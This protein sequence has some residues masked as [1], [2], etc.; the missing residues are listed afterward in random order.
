MGPEMNRTWATAI[1]LT[2]L[3]VGA[4][5]LRLPKLDLRPM[6]TDEAVQADKSRILMETGRYAYNPDEFHGPSLH[7][8]ALPSMW[9]SGGKYTDCSETTFRIVPAI[10]GGLLVALLW[11]LRDALGTPGMLCAAVLLALSPS[12]VF[13]SRYYI[14]ETPLIFGN[15]M[16]L[17]CAW[18]YLQ[19]P[20]IRW[21]ALTGL[22]LAIMY[23]TKETWV[24]N[25]AAAGGA[26]F[27]L[28]I[29]TRRPDGSR[30]P[31]KEYLGWQ[32]QRFAHARFGVLVFAVVG[33]LLFTAFFTN[34]R[35]PL[36]SVETYVA[37]GQRA[38]VGKRY[39]LDDTAMDSLRKAEVPEE[40]L[41]KLTPVRNAL[42]SSR[43][44][45]VAS[46][47]EALGEQD[48]GVYQHAMVKCATVPGPH[49]HS[50]YYFFK[51]LAY[52]MNL[53][54][55]Q[56]LWRF[57]FTEAFILLLA[58][59]G[60]CIGIAGWN[61]ARAHVGF[62]RFLTLYT[63]LLA[64]VYSVIPY[65][66]P[67]C[68]LGFH[69][70]FILL[71]G[72]GAAS[73]V[74]SL[75]G[76]RSKALAGVLTGL[77]CVILLAGSGH[78]FWQTNRLNYDATLVAHFRN[79]YVYG[80]TG[81]DAIS[82]AARIEELALLSPQGV[83]AVVL[84]VAPGND[85]WPLPYYLRRLKQKGF[86][87]EPPANWHQFHPVVIAYLD[88][89]DSKERIQPPEGYERAGYFGL[90]PTVNFVVFTQ[91]TVWE[92]FREKVKNASRPK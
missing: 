40:V 18:R 1:L 79:P 6:H 47:S 63:V 46:L 57:L 21:A 48:M 77:A 30:V 9:L 62:V 31:I 86:T 88:D 19:A 37:W 84:V 13:Y 49:D 10:L 3:V 75:L 24:F 83:N 41:A 4:L 72:M 73:I 74:G 71:G 17:G 20:S 85:Y 34:L 51:L 91:P 81:K 56:F 52:N 35:G 42:F 87:A 11:L 54:P 2:F 55:G 70:G 60:A 92:A 80:H 16:A 15:L 14:A 82:L 65:K 27:L 32:T 28:Y 67:W 59:M 39:K 89:P 90:R 23:T 78:L 22:G 25:V 7:Y 64:V 66:T 36:D 76:L 8:L 43:E 45:F 29:T 38:L 44:Q 58:I 12:M 53:G 69:L 26:V 33:V 68:M 61:P 50:W 5:A